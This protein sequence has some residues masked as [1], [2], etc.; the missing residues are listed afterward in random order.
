MKKAILVFPL[1]AFHIM[2]FGQNKELRNI[3][4]ADISTELKSS[5]IDSLYKEIQNFRKDDLGEYYHD[6]AYRWHY[7]NFLK[8]AEAEQLEKAILNTRNAVSEKEHAKKLDTISIRKSLYN[9]AHFLNKDNKTFEAINTYDEHLA[10]QLEDYKNALTRIDLSLL[11]L[12]IGDFEKALSLLT[13]LLDLYSK[14]PDQWELMLSTHIL[15]ADSYGS[16]DYLKHRVEI[17]KHLHKADSLINANNFEKSYRDNQIKVL[18]GNLYSDTEKFQDAIATYKEVLS[19]PNVFS[20]EQLAVVYNNTGLCYLE[21]NNLQAAEEN[22]NQSLNA[23]NNYS[24]PL[25]SLGDL[26]LKK[27]DFVKGLEYYQKAINKVIPENK[28]NTITDVPAIETL[29]LTNDKLSLL[30]HLVAKANGWLTYH[31]FQEN[32]AYL[33][34]ALLTFVK[35]DKLI[36]IIK[37]ESIE[38]QSKVYWRE[39]SSKLYSKAVETCFYLNKAEEAF[40]FM[41]RNKALLLLEDLTNEE[42]KKTAHLPTEL[43]QRE[44]NLRRNIYLAEN[45]LQELDS[46]ANIQHINSEIWEKKRGYKHFLDSLHNSYPDYAKFKKQV[47]VMTFKNLKSNYISQNKVTLNYILN[48]EE[49]YGLLT[50]ADTT[51]LFQL[52]DVQNLNKEVEKLTLALSSGVSDI[53]DFK[54]ISNAVFQKLM[55]SKIYNKIKGKQLTIIPDYTLQQIPFETLVVDT[56][57]L[58][59]LIQDVEIGYAYSISLLEHNQGQQN[60]TNKDFLGIAPIT[61]ENLELPEL[62]F[63]ENELTSIAEVYSGQ[64]L[65][66]E[67]ASK[68][69]FINNA[70]DSRIVHLATHADIGEGDNPWVAFSDSK[71]YLK[72][73]YATKTRADM[74]VLSACNTSTGE[75]KRGE[76]VMS[77]ARGFFYSGAKSVV[78]TLWPVADESGKEILINFYK[79]LDKGFTKSKALQKT[80]LNYLNTTEEEELKH[81]YYWAGF[82]VLGDNSPVSDKPISPWLL[83]GL[84][85][86]GTG[87]LIFGYKKLKRAE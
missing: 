7:K 47:D 81:P 68:T 43:A 79:N 48:K 78:S 12:E 76:G 64:L 35:A 63:S 44:Y 3:I 45:H 84:G 9:L 49:G 26:Y 65:L 8:T 4:D 13:Q 15:L 31:K 46:S 33:E 52:G 17:E 56:A 6:L 27:N 30:A 24:F 39:Q 87:L 36:D 38:F 54:T 2:L 83:V 82:V 5:K 53:N 19:N 37:Q 75:L 85:L 29:E 42:A 77:L 59:Y 71:M 62:Y 60:Q 58:K 51:E 10:F 66:K 20:S 16:M 73:I 61:F 32:D 57:E 34:Y 74:V 50:T 14:D 55:P 72:E 18:F 67:Q 28:S 80:K 22:F 23:N 41:E 70:N 69:N 1:L 11:Y 40:Y 25:E 21:N 86:V